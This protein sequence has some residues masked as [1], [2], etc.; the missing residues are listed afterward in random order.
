MHAEVPISRAG[1]RRCREPLR[2]RTCGFTLVELL[3]VITIIAIL[4]AILLPAVQAAREAARRMQCSNNLKQIGLAALNHEQAQGFLPSGGWGSWAGEPTRGFDKRQPGSWEYNLLPY[5]ELGNIHDLG[6]NEGLPTDGNNMPVSRMGPVQATTTPLGVY[7]CPTRRKV[8]VYPRQA[9]V[10]GQFINLRP[11]V[12]NV[13]GR[14]DYAACLGDAGTMITSFGPSTL[15]AGDNLPDTAPKGMPSWASLYAGTPGALGSGMGASG[16]PTGV[17]YRR[18]MV[19]L[20]DVKDGA[21]NTYLVGEKYL[22]PDVYTTGESIGDNQSWNSSFCFD[23][24]RWSGATSDP[25]ES[26]I[27]GYFQPRQD[28]PGLDSLEIFG[29]AHSTNFNMV[30]CDGSVHSINYSIDP[31]THHRLGNIADGLPLDPKQL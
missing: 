28:T 22:T 5:L 11:N 25:H 19:R 13:A 26:V 17:S 23:N 24:I 7:I 27:A 31:D 2:S 18:S 15:A 8:M 3:V 21:S 20:R 6:I 9:A 16:T 12:P 4:I 30:F 1:C 10:A 29:S 14:S